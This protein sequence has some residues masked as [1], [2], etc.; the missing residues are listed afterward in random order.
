MRCFSRTMHTSVAFFAAILVAPIPSVFPAQQSP[1]LKEDLHPYGFLIFA[2][3]DTLANLTDV[4]F[5][6]D[7]RLLASVN[8]VD[9]SGARFVTYPLGDQP[10]A[11]LLLFD[12]SQKILLKSKVMP[13]EKDTNS[14]RAIAGGRFALIND[15]G[16]PFCSPDLECG[17]PLAA[18]TSIKSSPAG[19]RVVVGGPA[20]GTQ[21]LLDAAALQ[22]L[23]RFSLTDADHGI[24]EPV[25]PEDDALLLQKRGQ[26]YRRLP[27]QSDRHLPFPCCS[28]RPPASFINGTTIA[29]F[30]SDKTL[31][32]EKPD[33]TILYR[34]PIR[35]RPN[36]DVEIIPAQSGARFCLHEKGWTALNSAMNLGIDEDRDFNVE[37]VRV[38]ASESGKV[39]FDFHENPH[40]YLTR[41]S[42]PALSPNGRR[43]AMI[44]HGFLEVLEIP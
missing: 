2:R 29:D 30:E 14:V 21:Q 11:K 3:V 28:F 1:L 44:R 32:V 22:V 23:D 26:W 27:G 8:Q 10:P 16:S 9:F 36:G 17:P 43:L 18:R 33:G 38:L 42:S 31:V 6:T 4:N 12:V 7:D 35:A 37:S 41:L 19:T 24:I 39:L 20:F 13:I 5:L 34:V 25:I 40:P 15:A